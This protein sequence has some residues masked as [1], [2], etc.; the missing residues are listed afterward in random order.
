M[1]SSHFKLSTWKDSGGFQ[2]NFCP[3][4]TSDFVLQKRRRLKF[5]CQVSHGKVNPNFDLSDSVKRIIERKKV[6]DREIFS[7][8]VTSFEEDFALDKLKNHV[9]V[10]QPI[11][12]VPSKQNFVGLVASLFFL[13]VIFDRVWISWRSQV[14]PGSKDD[15]WAQVP[16]SFS[17]FLKKNLQRKESVEWVNMVVGKLWK[18]YPAGLEN[19]IMGLL[20]PVI[21][22]LEKPDYV[23]RVEIKQFS[24]GNE[25]L[26][27]RNVERRTSRG[28]NDLQ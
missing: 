26:S 2:L 13:G 4:G 3:C 9:A 17:L 12:V 19:W 21:D 23:Q 15:F 25:P 6:N 10:I 18:V 1:D 16:T 28:A 11:P 20:Q 8:N 5:R 14:N 27:V 7:R 22:D 24:M